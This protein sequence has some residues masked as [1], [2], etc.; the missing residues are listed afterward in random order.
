MICTNCG[1]EIQDGASFCP[2]C[3]ALFADG[4]VRI[5]YEA[6]LE[7]S[8]ETLPV[9][10]AET[11]RAA[12]DRQKATI[13]DDLSA[14]LDQMAET[15]S[16]NAGDLNADGAASTLAAA[17][18]SSSNA[19]DLNADGAASTL[20]AGAASSAD[21]GDL[22]TD[23]AAADPRVTQD[24]EHA[25]EEDAE[26]AANTP[27]REDI[28]ADF[29]IDFGDSFGRKRDASS[30]AFDVEASSEDEDYDPAAEDE[31]ILDEFYKKALRFEAEER[32]RREEE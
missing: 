5:H 7:S 27:A 14:K 32:R 23:D 24:G 18:A 30:K 28:D 1:K 21:E 26:D 4:L 8:A 16:S 13:G 11:V 19:G 12:W 31:A 10:N 22:G 17:G 20:T 29:D 2:Y 25:S 9:Y 15:P 3:G 6:Q